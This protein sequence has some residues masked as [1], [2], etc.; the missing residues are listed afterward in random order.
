MKKLFGMRRLTLWLVA[1]LTTGIFYV[2]YLALRFETIRIGYEVARARGEHERLAATHRLVSLEVQSLR[3]RQR[4]G[5]IAS[6]S[7]GMGAPDVGRV[8]TIDGAGTGR[9]LGGRRAR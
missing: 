6:R 5:T 4:V 9:T 8:I 3:E 7:L 1:V 2:S